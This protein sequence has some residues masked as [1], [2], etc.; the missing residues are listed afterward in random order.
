MTRLFGGFPAEFYAAYQEARPALSRDWR[1]RIELWNLYPLMVHAQLFG[2][3]Y[4][5]SVRSALRTY[6]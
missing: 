2:G 3:H 5:N 1:S 6:V 4:V